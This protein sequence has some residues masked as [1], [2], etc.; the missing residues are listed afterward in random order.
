MEPG[1]HQDYDRDRDRSGI[2]VEMDPGQKQVEDRDENM[3]E[4]E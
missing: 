4:A 2:K 1:Y 3:T